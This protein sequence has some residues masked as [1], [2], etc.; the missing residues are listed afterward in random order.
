MDDRT[1]VDELRHR[2]LQMKARLLY[3]T[4]FYQNIFNIE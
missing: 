3:I 2:Y 4:T 1:S